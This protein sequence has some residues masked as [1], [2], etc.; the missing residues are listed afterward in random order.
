MQKV[1]VEFSTNLFLYLST[2]TRGYLLYCALSIFINILQI[3][4]LVSII[5]Y[6][7]K[8]S[9]KDTLMTEG[10]QILFLAPVNLLF[11]IAFS[12]KLVAQIDEKMLANC[13]ANFCCCCC[14]GCNFL[15]LFIFLREVSV[16]CSA[17]IAAVVVI[18][19]QDGVVNLILNYLS[20]IVVLEIDE[21]GKVLV[22][23][24]N[25]DIYSYDAGYTNGIF[26][27]K[28]YLSVLLSFEK[29]TV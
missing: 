22:R 23:P 3:T 9:K 29:A 8:K 24:Q 4:C 5:A 12:F 14:C 6:N 13:L 25:V 21:S 11:S 1:P 7:I 26:K 20:V 16:F 10:E 15:A 19:Q 17:F 28:M 18:N 27:I 2:T